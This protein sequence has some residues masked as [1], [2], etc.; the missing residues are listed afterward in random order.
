MWGSAFSSPIVAT[1]GGL[2]QVVVQTREKIA[3]VNSDDGKVLWEQPVEAYRG[4]NILTPVVQ[5][6][7]IFTSAYGGKTIGFKVVEADGKFTVTEAWKHKAQGYMSTP[8]VI[9]GIAYEHLKSQ[10]LMAIELETGRELWTSDQS[11]GKYMSLVAGGDCIL[12]LDQRGVLFLLRAS[13]EKFDLLDK[14]KLA[15]AETWAHLAVAGDQLFVREL[16]ALT[17]FRWSRDGSPNATANKR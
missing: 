9:E 16:N 15:E 2:R 4:M 3:G 1:L 17:A 13:K 10:R 5:N 7:M 11:F 6:D 14:R 12:A 8:V